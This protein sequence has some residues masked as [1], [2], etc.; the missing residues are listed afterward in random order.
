MTTPANSSPQTSP[1][2]APAAARTAQPV[3]G[4]PRQPTFK[5]PESTFQLAISN[6]AAFGDTDIFPSPLDRF[7]CSDV[8]EAPLGILK[9]I[10]RTFN[11]Y[12][13]SQP[14]ENINAL[15]PL[16]YTAFRWATQIDPQWNLY[17]L[18]LVISIAETIE[19]KR[20]T[21]E[22]KSVFSYRFSPDSAT[23]H[24]FADSTW[25]HYKQVALDKSK[26]YPF[27][28]LADVA[29]F[30]P[31][32][33]H[34]RLENELQRLGR[35]EEE[36]KRIMALLSRFSQTRSYGLPIGGPASR[37]LAEL[38]LN[39]VDLFLNRKGISFC[40]YVDDFHIFA[41]TKQEAYNHLAFLAQV[42]FNE[43]LSLQ[44]TKTRI[45]A[46]SELQEASAHLDLAATEKIQLLPPEARLMRISV[47]FDPY[48]PTKD[49]DYEAL[50]AAVGSID[51]VGI[52]VREIAKTYIDT[53]ITKQA[54]AAVRALPTTVRAEAIASLLKP[55]NLETLAPV[56]GNV[57][58][59]IRSL[60]SEIE[61][62][63][64]D[65]ADATIAQLLSEGSHLTANELNLSYLLHVYGQRQSA[66]K[67]RVLI[68]LYDRSS[69]AL[70]RREIIL[71]MAKWKATYWLSDVLRRFGS[72]SKWEKK[73]FIVAAYHM[74][75]EGEHWLDSAKFTFLPD[76]NAI[77]KWYKDRLRR[78]PEVPL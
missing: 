49:E 33:A 41:R 50:K 75:D 26:E 64:K 4:Q 17:F 63:T 8:P 77:R 31:R 55:S 6:V 28:L 38:A 59:L 37:I 5:L 46:S 58:R 19:S 29:D 39:P 54:I 57:M 2:A 14:P 10:D 12:L 32:V 48:S 65:L 40:R 74:N 70:V 60:Y 47:K 7:V 68:E 9:E 71:V 23:G 67:E 78:A 24:L 61:D 53:Q 25:R 73:A 35:H 69:S 42:L 1:L 11:E 13:A 34:H 36:G 72:L 56:F 30:Y 22:E 16:G 76:E 15:A 43:G 3:S 27:V 20:L 44:K 18:S 66:Q 51:I 52:L 45:L 21:P 62:E